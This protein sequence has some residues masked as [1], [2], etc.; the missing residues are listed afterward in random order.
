[1]VVLARAV[2]FVNEYAT[3][4]STVAAHHEELLDAFRGSTAT[5]KQ[6]WSQ[7]RRLSAKKPEAC[8]RRQAV[9]RR[10]AGRVIRR[11]VGS[12]GGNDHQA[13]DKPQC[14]AP[15]HGLCPSTRKAAC[16]PACTM[17]VYPPCAF[18]RSPVASRTA[19]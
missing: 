11:D 4:G 17:P 19:A 5:F 10:L 8:H 1:L 6:Y 18:R 3:G 13:R 15:R 9:A 12:A 16:S 2:Q 14:N 7:L